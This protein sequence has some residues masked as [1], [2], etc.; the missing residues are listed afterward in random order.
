MAMQRDLNLASK[1]VQLHYFNQDAGIKDVRQS[2]GE[3]EATQ[4]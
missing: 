3:N 4:Y 1:W 2:L